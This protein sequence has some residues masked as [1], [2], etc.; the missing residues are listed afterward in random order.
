MAQK[1]VTKLL[2]AFL[3][4]SVVLDGATADDKPFIVGVVAPMTGPLAEDG[5]ATHN[6]IELAKK[7]HPEMFKSLSFIFEDSQ[8][9]AKQAVTAYIKLR[10]VDHADL[11]YVWGNPTSEAVA[12]LAEQNG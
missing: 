1:F 12:P 10:T 4:I 11:I 2:A 8:Y 6:G 7:Q 5:V 9:D 3:L